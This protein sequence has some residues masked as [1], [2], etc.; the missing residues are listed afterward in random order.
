MR[1][2][3]PIAA[4]RQS[5]RVVAIIDCRVR[6]KAA[7]AGV[8]TTGMLPRPPSGQSRHL[9]FAC[10]AAA[11]PATPRRGPKAAAPAAL[12]GRPKVLAHTP[13]AAGAALR[14]PL[15]GT[16]RPAAGD[17]TGAGPGQRRPP[18]RTV[19]APLAELG[20]AA[21]HP[22]ISNSNAEQL[23]HPRAGQMRMS[24][25]TP[26]HNPL[27]RPRRGMTCAVR[28]ACVRDRCSLVGAWVRAARRPPTAARS[29]SRRPGQ[30]PQRRTPSVGQTAGR[31][32]RL[33]APPSP[34]AAAW[35]AS[36]AAGRL[37]AL[38][39]CHPAV[40]LTRPPLP[41]CDGPR[42][43]FVGYPTSGHLRRCARPLSG[44]KAGGICSEIRTGEVQVAGG[45]G[46]RNEGRPGA[47]R[48][49]EAQR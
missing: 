17:G 33:T 48:P 45:L 21:A 47:G 6:T 27:A 25:S 31:E 7:S 43:P 8:V 22:S 39:A 41:V 40:A 30:R 44:A 36:P 28:C 38:L 37:A 49:C 9:Q 32:C 20:A 11:A 3:T 42:R 4:G 15:P 35:P 16:A 34:L 29:R 24:R 26:L 13:A 1:A 10:Q 2:R 19:R 46:R 5:R 12:S 23:R 14:G 18:A